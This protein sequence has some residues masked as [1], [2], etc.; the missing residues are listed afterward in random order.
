[1]IARSH[2][3][4]VA[5]Q[6]GSPITSAPK[7]CVRSS[8]CAR[9]RGGRETLAEL[10]PVLG[11]QVEVVVSD[12]LYGANADEML[13][14]LREL[15]RDTASVMIV[16]HNPGMH[17]LS[18]ELTGDGD[19]AAISQLHTKFPTGALATLQLGKA[20]W[21]ELTAGQAYLADLV[22]PRPPK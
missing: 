22:L 19:E 8:C 7:L 6:G 20:S 1:M 10:T 11:D 18:L 16:G 13:G 2:P 17:D 14:Q 3:A 21:D 5:P 4:A 9:R 15:G 12:D